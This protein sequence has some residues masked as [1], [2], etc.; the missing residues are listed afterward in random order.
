M[1][2]EAAKA[3]PTED[4]METLASMMNN[5]QGATLDEATLLL[6]ETHSPWVVWVILGGLGGLATIMMVFYYFKTKHTGISST[7]KNPN[8][9][10]E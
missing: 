9:A 8:T 2:R 10:T 3:I 1:S 7:Q 6:W 4:V 5:G